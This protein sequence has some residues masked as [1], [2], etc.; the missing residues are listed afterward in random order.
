MLDLIEEAEE[1]RLARLQYEFDRLMQRVRNASDPFQGSVGRSINIAKWIFFRR[2]GGVEPFRGS[3][4]ER[5]VDYIGR[6]AGAEARFRTRWPSTAIGFAL[7]QIWL[8]ALAVDADELQLQ[9]ARTLVAL[10]VKAGGSPCSSQ[11]AANLTPA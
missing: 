10:S 8:E 4:L 5:K 7:F 1:L 6:L 11:P 2:F 3:S 9:F